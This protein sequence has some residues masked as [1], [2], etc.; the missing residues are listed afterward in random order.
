MFTMKL[1]APL[2]FTHFYKQTR[3][4]IGIQNCSKISQSCQMRIFMSS[5]Q[6]TRT[7]RQKN[8]G[9]KTSQMQDYSFTE[10]KNKQF[11]SWLSHAILLKLIHFNH[12]E[13]LKSTLN[14]LN[15]GIVNH[16]SLLKMYVMQQKTLQLLLSARCYK[17]IQHAAIIMSI[18]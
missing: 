10:P 13:F 18:L 16:I 17:I 2:F 9:R 11:S 3:L 1:P 14:C 6:E 5:N 15:F 4:D 12:Y 7:Q 8:T